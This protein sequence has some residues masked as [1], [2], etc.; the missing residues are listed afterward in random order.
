MNRSRL[1]AIPLVLLACTPRGRTTS[2]DDPATKSAPASAPTVRVERADTATAGQPSPVLVAMR[3]ELARAT[4]ALATHPSKPYYVSYRVTEADTVEIVASRGALELSTRDRDRVLDLEMRVGDRKF[5]NYHWRHRPTPGMTGNRSGGLWGQ[6][7]PIDDD[8]EA[9]TAALWLSTDAAFKQATAQYEH[10]KAQ[11]QLAASPKDDAADFSEEKPVV[12]IEAPAALAIDQKAWEARVRAVSKAFER[13]PHVLSSEVRLVASAGTRYFVSNQGSEV[14]S[15][16]QHTRIILSATA[17]ADDGMDLSHVDI[18]DVRDPAAL[19]DEADLVARVDRLVTQLE[20]LRKAPVADPFTGPAVLEGRAA[21]VYFHEVF[22]HRVEGHRQEDESEGQTFADKVGAA[23]MPPFIDVFDDPSITS[24][25][26]VFLNGHYRHDDEGVTASR[27]QLV[28]DGKLVGF[29]LSRT[30]TKDFDHSNGHGRAQAGSDVVARQGNLVVEPRE[31]LARAQLDDALVAEIK[32]QGKPYGLRFVEIDGGLTNTSRY[33]AQAFQVNPV[34]VY[35]VFPDGT[36]ELVRG[37][38][39]EGTPLSSLSKI[40]AAGD[41]YEVFN[42]YCGAESGF[43]PVSAAST[44]L[45]LS[46]IEIARAPAAQDRPPLLPP[47]AATV[48][49]AR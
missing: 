43:I 44:A 34:V 19:P 33:A 49:G 30:P 31:G 1:L 2:P 10:A 46:Q 45:L 13:H 39:L 8:P 26:G 25:D 11:L 41:R 40:V 15:G 7:L 48:G 5:D 32:R 24:I 27:A 18:V 38:T 29:L 20:A 16:Q 35:R 21:A 36:E 28:D 17:K 9:I 47:P 22:G 12:A 37:V 14:Q 42:G 23:V 4:S 3:T 6:P